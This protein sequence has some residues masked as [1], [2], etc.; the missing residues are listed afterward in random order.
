[1]SK[2]SAAWRGAT[3]RYYNAKRLPT[4][5]IIGAQ[6]AGTSALFSYLAQHPRMAPSRE[7]ELDFFG[8]D[9]MYTKGM[10]WYFSNWDEKQA[11]GKLRF[12][13]SPQYLA[14]PVAC[15]R[16]RETFPKVKLIVTLRDPVERA[17]S[18]WRMYRQ[19]LEYDPDF[20]HRLHR[21][22]YAPDQL[23][24]EFPRLDEEFEDFDFAIRREAE[25]MSRNQ[26]LTCSLLYLGLYAQQLRRYIDAF[27]S[28]Q[29]LVLD[30][31]DLKLNRT[32]TLNRVLEF[33]GMPAWDW[34]Q[35]N[36]A[37]V[38]VGKSASQMPPQ[39]RAFLENFYRESNRQLAEMLPQPPRFVERS[40]A[41]RRAAA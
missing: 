27:S 26:H 32:A 25:F 10:D 12:E 19:Q 29:L 24:N 21:E 7:K 13:A 22:R 17:Y 5:L 14:A 11:H 31:E 16:I 40:L 39:S 9:F 38:F 34:S 20:Y 28:S 4:V 41:R 35:A 37:D 6:K 23:V 33:L 30:S 36:L 2:L 8:S 18:S 15:G 3:F 1:M